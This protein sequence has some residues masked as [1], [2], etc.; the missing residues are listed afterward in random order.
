MPQKSKSAYISF[1]L[2]QLLVNRQH[3]WPQI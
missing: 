2:T 3:C 1:A